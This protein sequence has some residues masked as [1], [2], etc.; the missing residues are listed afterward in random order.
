ML[1]GGRVS[2]RSD[3]SC[4]RVVDVDQQQARPEGSGDRTARVGKE[5][6]SSIFYLIFILL[7]FIYL[8]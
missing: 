5:E 4:R 2:P 8:N 6:P 7:F 3:G 1:S